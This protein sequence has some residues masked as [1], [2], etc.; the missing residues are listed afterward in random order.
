MQLLYTQEGYI[1]QGMTIMKEMNRF[2]FE[3]SDNSHYTMPSAYGKSV[4]EQY[5]QQ[6]KY[7]EL[8]KAPGKMDKKANKQPGP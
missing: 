4:R 7:C 1:Y 2:D 3:K 6:P 8:G 5:N